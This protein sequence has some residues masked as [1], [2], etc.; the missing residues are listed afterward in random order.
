[1]SIKVHAYF[2]TIKPGTAAEIVDTLEALKGT[3]DAELVSVGERQNSGNV[4][5][6]VR[7]RLK[8]HLNGWARK[9]ESAGGTC[10]DYERSFA[11]DAS[12]RDIAA[13][14][15]MMLDAPEDR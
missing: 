8:A 15:R 4:W 14:V 10:F 7:R 2:P 13:S 11:R 9:P 5:V 6:T 1:M 12:P 3:N